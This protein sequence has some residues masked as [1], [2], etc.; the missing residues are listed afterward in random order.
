LVNVAQARHKE[1]DRIKVMHRE[2]AKMAGRSRSFRTAV[3]TGSSLRGRRFR[4]TR[5]IES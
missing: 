4:D 1:T 5:T 2:L 3:I